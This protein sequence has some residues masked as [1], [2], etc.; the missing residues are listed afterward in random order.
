MHL[1][2]RTWHGWVLLGAF[3]L[4]IVSL[5]LTVWDV[6]PPPSPPVA[7]TAPL[8][9]P[10]DDGAYHPESGQPGKDVVW[11]PSANS[12]VDTMLDLAGVT[13]RDVV[14]D[15]G[16][17][18]G[19]TVIAAAQR[20]ARAQ[21]IEY[22]PDLVALS[23]RRAAQAAGV[24]DR[25][26]FVEGDIFAADFSH[27]TVV[28]MFLLPELNLRLRPTLL[29]LAPGT[30]IVSNT[31]TMDDWMPDA[32]AHADADCENWCTAFLWVV[33][34]HAAGRW[35]MGEASLT[36]TQQFQAVTGTLTSRGRT[37]Q[38][39]NGRLRGTAIEFAVDDVLYTGTVTGD[40][41]EGEFGPSGRG[42]PWRASRARTR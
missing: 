8:A 25:A 19:R 39:V 9:Q 18:D 1:R 2:R 15:L 42:T 17:G 32:T 29:G 24:G 41:A 36:L 12:L 30:R 11:V 22:N 35:S 16:S 23:K 20:G 5:V 38:V 37:R 14:V 26:A 21:G 40:T 28:T 3:T 13:A 27:A 34:T 33:P 31:F 6:P 7:G 4:L 10:R